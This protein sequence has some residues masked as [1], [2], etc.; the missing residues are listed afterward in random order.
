MMSWMEE[1]FIYNKYM[2]NHRHLNTQTTNQ[3][4]TWR[5]SDGPV[6]VRGEAEIR[7]R[8]GEEASLWFF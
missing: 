3:D 1:E 8:L 4:Q 2:L 5:L 6:G 7:D